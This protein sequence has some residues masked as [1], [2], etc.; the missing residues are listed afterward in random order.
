[1]SEERTLHES[2]QALTLVLVMWRQQ[3]ET[4]Q[5]S[6]RLGWSVAQDKTGKQEG[7]QITEGLMD[8]YKDC[9][10]IANHM[11]SHWMACALE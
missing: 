7:G 9:G 6:V 1:M 5:R 3:Q 4:P 10:F 2:Q 11:G 8:H